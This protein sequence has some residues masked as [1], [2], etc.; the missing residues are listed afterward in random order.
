MSKYKHF[1]VETIRDV[2]VLRLIDPQLFDTLIVTE[3][4]DELIDFVEA[5]TPGKVLINFSNVSHCSTAVINSLLRTKKRLIRDNG[6]LKLCGM[7]DGLR[8]AYKMLN[9]DGTV[10]DIVDNPSDGIQAFGA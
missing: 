7:R 1:E 2:S 4:Q 3:L 9:L 8:E 10:F 5:A 6:R